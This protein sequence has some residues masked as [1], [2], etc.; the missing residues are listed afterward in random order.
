M[1]EHYV[2][3]F[4]DITEIREH[5]RQLEHLAHFDAL[6]NLPNRLLLLDRLSQG[7]AQAERRGKTLA[8]VYWLMSTILA[9]RRQLSWPVG[10]GELIRVEYLAVRFF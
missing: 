9:A 5:Q 10:G 1:V 6:T 8:I 2:A 4:T 7:L 3:L